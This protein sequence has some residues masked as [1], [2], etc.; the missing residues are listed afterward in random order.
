[1]LRYKR[2]LKLWLSELPKWYI[3]CFVSLSLSLLLLVCDLFSSSFQKKLLLLLLFFVCE[4]HFRF[5]LSSF[6][7]KWKRSLW[8]KM[9]QGLE[10]PCCGCSSQKNLQTTKASKHPSLAVVAIKKCPKNFFS[11]VHGKCYCRCTIEFYLFP[12]MYTISDIYISCFFLFSIHYALSLVF[13]LC[14]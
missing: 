11:S 8:P 7:G 5:F 2:A 6:F 9:M 4:F 12:F 3:A 13:V 10:T 14:C 1:M